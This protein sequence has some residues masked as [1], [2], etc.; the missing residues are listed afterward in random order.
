MIVPQDLSKTDEGYEDYRRSVGEIENSTHQKNL[1]ISKNY[2]E[3]YLG[4]YLFTS[5]ERTDVSTWLTKLYEKGYSPRTVKNAYTELKKVYTYYFE[6]GDIYKNPFNGVK[7]PKEGKPKVTHL[8]TEQMDQFLCAVYLE[9]DPTEPMYV[10]CLLAYYSGLR[11]GE[12]C[13]LRWRNIDFDINTITVD[14]AIGLGKGGNY[15][16]PPKTKSSN[17]SFPILPQLREALKARYDALQPES[18]W[19]VIGNKDSFMSLQ[20]FT[21]N[22]QTL[23][24]AYDLKDCYG[25]KNTPHSLRHNLATVGIR[26]GMDIASLASMMGHASRAMTLDT[27]PLSNA[28]I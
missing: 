18:G 10:G 8:T 22:F 13:A 21:N 16:K 3:P 23:V 14:S 26:S 2:I 5:V 27:C 25:K 11:R 19:F 17:R 7:A 6:V 9:Y 24:D 12:I 1:T 4:N 20:A 15:T 28:I